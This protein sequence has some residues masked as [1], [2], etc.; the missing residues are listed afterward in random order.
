MHP[1]DYPW[2]FGDPLFCDTP[3]PN[4]TREAVD[5][6]RVLGPVDD[7]PGAAGLRILLVGDSTACSLFPGLRAVG[8]E[9]GAFV[10]Q[11]AVFGCGVASGE[12]TTTRNEQITPHTE[13]CQDMVNEAVDPA[14]FQLRPQVVVWMSIW[15]KSDLVVDGETLVSGTAAGDAE[16]QRRMDWEL[17]AALRRTAPRLFCSRKRRR[18]PTTCR[19][20][21]TR[22]TR[23]TT[24][25]T[26]WST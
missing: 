11:A 19:A 13:R 15:E 21:A 5:A 6:A 10:A 8:E 18:H 22:A 26:R 14:I 4:E 9:A 12:I 7:V 17:G 25:A 16:M 24:R 3:R 2:S 23:S 1:K 20:R